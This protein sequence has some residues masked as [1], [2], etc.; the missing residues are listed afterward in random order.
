MR[1]S[2]RYLGELMTKPRICSDS[3]YAM[4]LLFSS[5]LEPRCPL[6]VCV[7][8]SGVGGVFR[9]NCEYFRSLCSRAFSS[10]LRVYGSVRMLLLVVFGVLFLVFRVCVFQDEVLRLLYFDGEIILKSFRRMHTEILSERILTIKSCKVD[11]KY[12]EKLFNL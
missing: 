7:Y 2:L 12:G 3:A 1:D 9:I 8:V 5:R 6:C 4:D 11:R 10:V